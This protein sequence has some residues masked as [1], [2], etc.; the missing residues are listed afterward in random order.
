MILVLVQRANK[1]FHGTDK[2]VLSTRTYHCTCVIYCSSDKKWCCFQDKI[3][4]TIRRFPLSTYIFHT[5]TLHQF[6]C[7]ATAADRWWNLASFIILL[8]L[9][10]PGLDQ[11]QNTYYTNKTRGRQTRARWQLS[12]LTHL[13]HRMPLNRMKDSPW[14]LCPNLEGA[15]R[16]S[17]AQ[18]IWHARISQLHRTQKF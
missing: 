8:L 17:C 14:H 11:G 6:I 10:F 5:H 1:T 16:T 7:L 3:I 13:C 2:K 12:P 15:R 9:L 18:N 4:Y